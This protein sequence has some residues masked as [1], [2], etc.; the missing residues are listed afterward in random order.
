MKNMKIPSK[1][2][3][4]LMIKV[5]T[6]A[7][8]TRLIP[9]LLLI[10]IVAGLFA[11]FAVINRLD[12]V[13]KAEAELSE[14]KKHLQTVENIYA[15]YDEVQKEYNRYTYQNFD[16]TIPDRLDVL[17]MV[18]RQLFTIGTVKNITISGRTVSLTLEG[19]NLE[20]VSV[21]YVALY[22]E[23]LVEDV[24]ISSYNEQ[25]KDEAITSINMTIY[26]VDATTLGTEDSAAGAENGG[27]K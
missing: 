5:K 3:L 11:K 16:R 27:G 14:M 15:D 19:P 17:Q 8:P 26:L 18:E 21:L 6:L 25:T 7:H 12:Q 9:I 22:S 2:T 10:V 24:I 4:N 23:P 13:N 1:K 20:D